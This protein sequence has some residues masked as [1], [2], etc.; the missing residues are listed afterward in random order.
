M[1]AAALRLLAEGAL[2]RQSFDPH[3]EQ[4]HILVHQG[5]LEEGVL[6]LPL[7]RHPVAP[8]PVKQ[9]KPCLPLHRVEKLRLPIDEIRDRLLVHLFL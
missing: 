7:K 1:M 8:F 5:G 3:F 9:V 6:L 2:A 4:Q